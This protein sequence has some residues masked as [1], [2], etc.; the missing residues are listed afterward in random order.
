MSLYYS[1]FVPGLS[2]PVEHALTETLQCKVRLVLDGLIAYETNV[3]AAAVKALPFVTNT[4]L[5]FKLFP[6]NVTRSVREMALQVLN[7][8]RLVVTVV[9][10]LAKRLTS[11]R[12]I[13]SR[14]NQL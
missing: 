9:P 13:I 14:A 5:V 1:T 8:S 7:D 4:F 6:S 3:D 12:I 10:S 11:F 2:S